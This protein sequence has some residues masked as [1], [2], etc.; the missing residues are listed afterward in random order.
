[1]TGDPFEL[2]R[3]VT[4][5]EG[6]IEQALRELRAGAKRG[7]WMWFI[8]PQLHGLGHSAMAQRYAIH[9]VEEARAYLAH[10][11]LGPRLQACC[12]ALL[13]AGRD[14]PALTA[15]G[16]LGSPDDLKL[17]SCMTLFALTA[18]D[19]AP[20]RAV[21]KRYCDGAVDKRSL[22]HLRAKAT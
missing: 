14:D 18:D 20:F 10:E 11:V 13:D 4:A 7:H 16:A 22:A 17:R 1:M 12:H 19:D 6:V 9:G 21:L 15:R 2:T 8:F 5:Q 3:F